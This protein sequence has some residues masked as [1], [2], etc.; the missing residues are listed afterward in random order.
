MPAPMLASILAACLAVSSPARAAELDLPGGCATAGSV[1]LHEGDGPRVGF[2]AGGL[3][4]L[5]PG[6]TAAPSLHAA[7]LHADVQGP[8]ALAPSAL[9]QASTAAAAALLTALSGHRDGGCPDLVLRQALRPLAQAL[10]A[11]DGAGFSWSGVAVRAGRARFGARHL[12]LRLTGGPTA[13]LEA[14]LD[15]VISNGEAAALTPEALTLRVSIPA[16]ELPALVA[17]ARDS[18][19]QMTVEALHATRGDSTLDGHGQAL[20]GPDTQASAGEGEVS[21]RG[22]DGL[23]DAAGVPG[24]ERLHTALFLA[25]LVAHRSGDTLAW[26]LSWR[27]GTLLVNNVPLPLR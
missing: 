23:I 21:V 5:L 25:R 13:R 26:T 2:D 4:L 16:A 22:F 3:E 6:L 18:G 27:D 1:S 7:H 24:L 14:T 20:L 12:S 8:A 15:G 10:R 17:G 11:G 9:E 19:I